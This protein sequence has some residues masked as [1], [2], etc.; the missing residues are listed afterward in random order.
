MRAEVRV[1]G[2]IRVAMD[3]HTLGARDFGGRKPKQLLE[4]LVLSSDRHVAKERL[5]HLLWGDDLPL[6]ATGA[7]EHYIS[8]LRRRLDPAGARHESLIVT[9]HGGYRFD[10]GRAWVDLAEFDSLYQAAVASSD[11]PAM[12]RALGLVTGDLLEDEPYSEWAQSARRDNQQHRLRLHVATGEL[13]LAEGDDHAAAAHA[14]AALALDGL[15]EAAV[16]LLMTAS[17]RAGEQSRALRTFEQFRQALA[18]D[19]GAEPMPATLAVHEAVLHQATPVRSPAA[20]A[21]ERP[22]TAIAPER[23]PTV[24]APRRPPRPALPAQRGLPSGGGHQSIAFGQPS[25]VGR[26]RELDAC[27]A[28]LDRA[29]PVPGL[30]SVLVEGEL[31][32]GKTALLDELARRLPTERTVRAA[33]TRHA[34]SVSGSLLEEVLC[35]LLGADADVLD[36][37]DGLVGTQAGHRPLPLPVLRRL[38]VR[39]AAAGPFAVLVDD[40]HLADERS[41]LV[42]LAL[43]RRRAVIRGTVILTA[44]LARTPDQHL[45]HSYEP[46]LRVALGPLTRDHLLTLGVPDVYERT[47]GVPLLVTGCASGAGPDVDAHVAK[48]VL[49]RLGGTAGR[50]WRVLVGC[51]TTSGAFGP[52]QVGRLARLDPLEVVEILE[53]LCRERVLAVAGAAYR[54]RHP[55]VRQIVLDAVS[56][57]RRRLLEARAGSGIR[58]VP[59]TR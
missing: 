13:A 18:A 49:D 16:R 31:G 38:D 21:P 52:E 58:S 28:L 47:G 43:G 12:E 3:G 41:L 30:R 17:Y 45:L 33:C 15:H 24:T 19:V 22:P 57:G 2:S 55:L 25:L 44:D 51:A 53:R 27:Q 20:I 37:L 46:D 54:F 1:F 36:L 6:N 23:P 59:L 56:P 7:L 42:L 11:R 48:R 9:D 26:D 4:I 14:R 35:R 39:L 29:D 40:A 50:T 8:L 5:A 34:A 32:I 10:A